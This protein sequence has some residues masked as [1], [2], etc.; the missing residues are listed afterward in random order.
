MHNSFLSILAKF[1][2]PRPAPGPHAST[3]QASV[4]PAMQCSVFRRTE[5]T[6]PREPECLILL[7]DSL[8]SVRGRPD[9]HLDFLAK[10]RVPAEHTVSDG[11]DRRVH[12]GW[13]GR[14]SSSG[15]QRG[16]MTS[17]CKEGILWKDGHL[18]FHYQ[19][20]YISKKK[21]IKDIT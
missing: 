5:K 8:Q 2:P 3:N 10:G 13:G 7:H 15:Q 16:N 6:V 4:K 12:P 17:T 14:V 19:L 11:R 1:L 20:I 21:K 18:T 9:R